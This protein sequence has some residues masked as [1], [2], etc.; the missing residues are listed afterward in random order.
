MFQDIKYQ[1]V[2]SELND[3]INGDNEECSYLNKIR[4]LTEQSKVWLCV[5]GRNCCIKRKA[6]FL[7][8]A[9]ERERGMQRK[10]SWPWFSGR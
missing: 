6:M 1:V 4:Q 3:Q 2:P 10:M 9:E 8:A 5:V 7:L